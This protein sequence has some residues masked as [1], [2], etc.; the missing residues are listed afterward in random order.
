M[1]TRV[2]TEI[3]SDLQRELAM[4][5]RGGVLPGGSL[6]FSLRNT[7]RTLRDPLGLIHE[8]YDRYG[9][10]FTIR[11]LHF[12]FVWAL[13]AQAT[14]EIT[15][16]K[17]E[18][19]SWR[20]GRYRDLHPL[21]GDGMLNIDGQLHW[22]V[23]RV[24]LPAF[25]REHV[26]GLTSTILEEAVA[27]RATLA[28]G[29][30]VDLYEWTRDVAIRIALR[31]LLGLDLDRRAEHALAEAYEIALAFHG[32]PFYKQLVRGPGTPYARV[33]A[34]RRILDGYIVD[35]IA[36]RRERDEPGAGIIGMLLA[37]R[38]E[39]GNP[40]P[41]QMIRDHVVTILF[42]GHD[43]TTATLT[44]LLH[45]L[46]HAPAAREALRR[47]PPAWIG[48]RRTVEDVEVAGVRVPA[49]TDI[50]YTSWGTHHLHDLWEDPFRFDPD[51]FLPE[52]F[53]AMPKG[54]Y[55]PFGGGSRTCLGK[56][57]G[58]VELRALTAVLC[59]NLRFAAVAGQPLEVVTT[60]TLG[61]KDG[62]SLR[63]TRR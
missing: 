30:D 5:R 10:V 6:H 22:G 17:A 16:S 58:E 28:P 21:L 48:P 7:M 43:T 34:N 63:V 27:A 42:A 49:N 51:R 8:H 26:M 35:E 4:R 9:P 54:A 24:L 11:T 12:P 20:E 14:H 59:S 41:A 2:T 39:H 23:R 56:R 57:F 3:A 40:L 1:H 46:A 13:G 18:S 62:L 29:T 50:H 15:V 38:D 37:A 61:P 60:P 47:W 32:E 45:E 55:I 36:R 25:H 31:A 44:F 19:F 53:A 33:Q 52:R